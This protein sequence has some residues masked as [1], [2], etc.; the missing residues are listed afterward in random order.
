[1]QFYTK[2]KTIL[3]NQLHNFVLNF[4]KKN[5][6]IRHFLVAQANQKKINNVVNPFLPFRQYLPSLFLLPSFP[7]TLPKIVFYEHKSSDKLFIIYS[8]WKPI[9]Y[10]KKKI[11]LYNDNNNHYNHLLFITIMIIFITFIINIGVNSFIIIIYE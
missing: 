2:L 9:K 1:M 5:S 3:L 11:I 8:H 10:L 6:T 7:L 4:E